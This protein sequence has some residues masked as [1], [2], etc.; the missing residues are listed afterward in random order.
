ME[1]KLE[2]V[3]TLAPDQASIK[4]AKKLLSPTKWPVRQCSS[5]I[6]SIWGECQGSGS[7]PY[8]TVADVVDHGYK[9][10]CPSRKFPCKHVL[11]LMWQYALNPDD[12]TPSDSP[13]WVNDWMGRRRKNTKN[14]ALDASTSGPKK[15]IHQAEDEPKKALTPEEVAKQEAA[16]AKRA[17]KVRLATQASIRN[18]INDYLQWVDDLFRTGIDG[19]LK[20]IHGNCRK[21]AAR[22][23]DAKAA[24]IASRM[25]ELPSAILSMP[26]QQQAVYVIQEIGKLVLLGEAWLSHPEDPDIQRAMGQTETREQV[27]NNPENVRRTHQ[28]LVVGSESTTRKDGLIA[29]ATWLLSQEGCHIA[30]LLDY[31]PAAVGNRNPGLAAGSMIEGEVVYYP[32][33]EPLRAVLGHY[34]TLEDTSIETWSV[35]ESDPN[36][37]YPEHL[38]QFPWSTQVPFFVGSSRIATTSEG[39]SQYWLHM[40]SGILPIK[41]NN[42]NIPPLL[43]AS[44]FSYAFLIWQGDGATLMS[45]VTPKWGM[46]TC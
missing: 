24:G 4:A 42:A 29:Q 18:G 20:D 45:A 8:Y 9:C 7:K 25:D 19:F 16:K 23:V 12:F 36:K 44:P 35:E 17:E 46:L 27:L 22:M 31:F 38:I 2:T 21:I 14:Q 33:K 6:N 39:S 1:I 26:P 32:S 34:Q 5:E 41:L 43:F 3:E 10:T 30:L 28:W 40:D 15:N 37:V 11:A 13:D